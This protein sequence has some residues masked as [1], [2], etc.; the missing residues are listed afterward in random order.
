MR[1]LWRRSDEHFTF[2]QQR[3][4]RTSCS[5][6][7]SIEHN[8]SHD[9]AEDDRREQ[10]QPAPMLGRMAQSTDEMAAI[11]IR[12][13]CDECVTRTPANSHHRQKSSDAVVRSTCRREKYACGPWKRYC[14][15]DGNSACAPFPKKVENGIQ[16]PMPELAV[17]VSRSGF[18]CDSE[19]EV[20]ADH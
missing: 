15:R 3:A 16:F 19:R 8:S 1:G 11:V 17:Q 5:R 6:Q 9:Q 2:G 14:R 13:D 12:D 18:S 20:C 10:Q 7:S 4:S